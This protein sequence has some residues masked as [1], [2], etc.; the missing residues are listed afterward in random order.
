MLDAAR[1]A[2]LRPRAVA[3]RGRCLGD[4]EQAL[5]SLQRL[6]S[7]VRGVEVDVRLS[8]D[9]VPVL[10][11]DARVDRTTDGHGEVAGLRADEIAALTLWPAER[12]PTLAAYLGACAQRDMADVYLHL[13]V[14][15]EAAVAAVAADV[16][17]TGMAA[18]TVLL[19]RQA[20]KARRARA[21]APE[22]RLG[23]LGTTRDTLDERLRLAQQG[24]VWLL[25]AP[26][27]DER[28]LAQRDV[29]AA[30]RA[31][32]VRVGA[33]TLRGSCAHRAAVDDGCDVIISDSL[34]ALDG[35]DARS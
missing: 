13:K 30:V 2:L 4:P 27:G 19:F 33:S 8:A 17:A 21:V 23:L 34:H 32:G 3:H 5:S 6:P 20:K 15:T 18:R 29:V 1:L 26:R 9:G 25:L 14:T 11:H 24:G 28:Y 7:W 31:A 35:T 10:M 22:V 16:R 12:V